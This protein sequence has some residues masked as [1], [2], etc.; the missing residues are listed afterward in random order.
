LVGA[1]TG[2]A[3]GDI[4]GAFVGAADTGA[5]LGAAL[6][7]AS[8]GMQ[9]A[10]GGAAAQDERLLTAY[11]N[12]M[13]ARGYVVNGAMVPQPASYAEGPDAVRSTSSAVEDRLIRLRQLHADGL[14][15]DKEYRDRRRAI[16]ADL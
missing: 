3:L 13:L 7:G 2:A 11:A 9:G 6:G 14:I 16:L 10:G 12:C 5:A 8:G 15:T 1:A 4:A